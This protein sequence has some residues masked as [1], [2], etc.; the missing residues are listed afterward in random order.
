MQKTICAVVPDISINEHSEFIDMLDKS[1][2][3][4]SI[5]VFTGLEF[6]NPGPK[7]K[8]LP[9]EGLNPVSSYKQLA[10]ECTQDYFLILSEKMHFYLGQFC[11]E[12][13]I[14]V[15]KDTGA[16]IVYSDFI[17]IKDGR[18][19]MRPVIDYQEGSL[20][21]DFK[22]GP[23][24]LISSEAFKRG[25]SEMTQDVEMVGLY[26]LR[27]KISQHFPIIHVPEY[28]YSVEEPDSKKTGHTIFEHID[29]K[30]KELQIELRKTSHTNF[31]YV[32]PKNREAQI[33]MEK[34]VTE[35]LKD[36][37]AYLLPKFKPVSF[38]ESFCYYSCK[39]PDK[40][41]RRCGPICIN[42]KN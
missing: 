39:R 23:L 31:N 21:D 15:A 3:V 17:E 40:N 38:N 20:R 30:F 35:H 4:E 1:E 6:K 2:L 11:I 16:G 14:S 32:N 25:V 13:M 37:G 19:K 36:I 24:I 5:V 10:R 27:L 42:P 33:E 12:R 26:Y 29:H 28:L 22:F 18:K 9:K 34:V 8:L 41:N 7:F